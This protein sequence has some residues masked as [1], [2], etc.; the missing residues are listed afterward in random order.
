MPFNITMQNRCEALEDGDVKMEKRE[1]KENEENYKCDN[2]GSVLKTRKGLENHRIN[3]HVQKKQRIIIEHENTTLE[4]D[5]S[6]LEKERKSHRATKLT[7][8]ALENEYKASR[9]E[10]KIV[11]AG[12]KK[13]NLLL[14]LHILAKI[15]IQ[16]YNIA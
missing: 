15:Y 2:C 1:S 14:P 4:V 12:A 3:A 10:L 5:C 11:S 6:E 13:N 7:L 9:E 16:L 8:A